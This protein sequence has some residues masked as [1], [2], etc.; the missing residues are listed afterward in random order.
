MVSALINANLTVY[1]KK[2]RGTRKR[3]TNDGDEYAVE[4]IDDLEIF[5]ILL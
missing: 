1:E 2:D 4:P 5:D 3:S